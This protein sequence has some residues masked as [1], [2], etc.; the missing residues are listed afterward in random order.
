MEHRER[1]SVVLAGGFLDR[2]G[3]KYPEGSHTF[4]SPVL[5]RPADPERGRFSIPDVTIGVGFHWEREQA[6]T[7]RGSLA[8]EDDGRGLT[9]INDVS[10]EDYVGS[11]IASEMSAAS[12]LEFLKAHAVISRS[13]VAAQIAATGSG[14][15]RRETESPSREPEIV[16]WYG[17]DS[18][19]RFDVCADD[20]CQRYQGEPALVSESVTRAIRETRAEYLTWQGEVCDTRFSKCCG[21]VTEGF[22]VAWEDRVVPYLTPV[23]DGEGPMPEVDDS[24]L[25]ARPPAWCNTTDTG[26][27]ERIL[28][29]FDQETTDFFRWKRVETPGA[30]G[31]TFARRTGRDLGPITALEP[32]ARS[33]SGRIFRLR[34]RGRNGSLIV[35]K[36]LEIRRVLSESHLYSSAF[37][38]EVGPERIV[39][40]GAGWG[41]GVG[42]CQIGAGALAARGCGYRE[43]LGHYYPEA[44]VA[45]R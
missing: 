9:V 28:P 20:H 12:P 13:W 41:H 30:L 35:G 7:F 38:A 24:W 4:T 10:I 33:A 37:V 2:A 26:F 1:V 17:R 27:L 45:V 43:I 31:A 21:G 14:D 39:L 23:H 40:H 5:L 11:V 42:L 6:Q 16:A 32:L 15:F 22:S 36:E 3:R 18:H 8:I 44:V 19:T 25:L 34:V 29:G